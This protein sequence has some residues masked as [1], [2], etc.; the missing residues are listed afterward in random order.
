MMMM[1]MMM[2]MM[3]I[4]INSVFKRSTTAVALLWIAND[5]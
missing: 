1:M 4:V 2:M 3:N 5:C